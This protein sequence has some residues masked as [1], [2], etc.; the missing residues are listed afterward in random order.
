MF[1]QCH[2]LVG[3]A[4]GSSRR[5]SSPTADRSPR[6]PSDSV[7]TG[8]PAVSPLMRR[9]IRRPVAGSDLNGH[10]AD[11]R[12]AKIQAALAAKRRSSYPHRAS[13]HFVQ[14]RKH[15]PLYPFLCFLCDF[16][17]FPFHIVPVLSHL[18]L[19]SST[20][21][22]LTPKHANCDVFVCNS[23][24]VFHCFSSYHYVHI[25]FEQNLVA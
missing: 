12:R 19:Y 24:R 20:P 15:A 23:F 18:S 10:P 14:S 11:L 25:F 16:K 7:R 9:D 4:G 3:S 8:R 2:H 6:S 17:R 13:S 5:S 21:A 22:A 1:S